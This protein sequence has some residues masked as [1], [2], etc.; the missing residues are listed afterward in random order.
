MEFT[1]EQMKNGYFAKVI[2]DAA[3]AEEPTPTFNKYFQY[4]DN[5]ASRVAYQFYVEGYGSLVV[6]IERNYLVGSLEERIT[7]FNS[8]LWN[9]LG[10]SEWHGQETHKRIF[11][12]YR[13][14]R[15]DFFDEF[16]STEDGPANAIDQNE[17]E[18]EVYL[19]A[20]K[21]HMA[22][23]YLLMP[24]EEFCD[25]ENFNYLVYPLVTTLENY[26]C[27][28]LY[29]EEL[30]RKTN[31]YVSGIRENV[32][33]YDLP[34]K[35]L[36][37]FFAVERIALNEAIRICIQMTRVVNAYHIGDLHQANIAIDNNNELRILD[38]GW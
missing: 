14:E 23:D 31:T 34:L 5:G 16:C 19:K 36:S 25:T 24:I 32:S 20:R 22:K 12:A 27:D 11:K 9:R 1:R 10:G 17:R 13:E 2:R 35:A 4:I 3:H 7:D 8:E 6:K 28:C 15:Q 38:Y 37:I 29:D 33:S 26:N 21:D 30:K 18:Y